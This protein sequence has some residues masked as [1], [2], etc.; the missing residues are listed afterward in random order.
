MQPSSLEAMILHYADYT[1]S[2]FVSSLK[3]LSE[4]VG[5]DAFTDRKGPFGVP[6][7]KPTLSQFTEKNSPKTSEQDK[8]P[9]QE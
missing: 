7:L 2:T 4:D 6:L 5:D 1:D 3:T 9:L 8:V